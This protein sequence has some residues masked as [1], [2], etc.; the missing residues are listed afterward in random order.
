MPEVRTIIFNGAWVLG[1][2]IILAAWSYARYTAY[3]ARVKTR[4]VL[5]RLRYVVV[6][7]VGLLL[8]AGGMAAT[9]GPARGPHPVGRHR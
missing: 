1:L 5:R 9:E 3:E 6:M 4:V 7:D 8:F 2:S